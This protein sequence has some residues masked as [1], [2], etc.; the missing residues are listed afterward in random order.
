MINNLVSKVT[1]SWFVKISLRRRHVLIVKDGA[2]SHETDYVT[3]LAVSKSQRHPNRIIGSKFTA[4]LLN[5][6]ILPIGGVALG[7]GLCLQP[8]Q[9]AYFFFL[10]K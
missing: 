10:K 8:V 6:W 7:R 1:K 2:Y 4:I 9:Q 3:F 5:G